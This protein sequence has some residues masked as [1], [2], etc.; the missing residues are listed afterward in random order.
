MKIY[1]M[2]DNHTFLELSK[3]YLTAV[4]ELE[5]EFEK[6]YTFGM[7]CSFDFPN[8]IHAGGRDKKHQ[9][10]AEVKELYDSIKKGIIVQ[11]RKECQ[12]RCSH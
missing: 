12:C 1:Y 9:F 10:L 3:D 2:R 7:V 6:G 8:H 4:N 11:S 5:K